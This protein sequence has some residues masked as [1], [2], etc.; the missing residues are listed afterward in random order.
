MLFT[1]MFFSSFFKQ[2]VEVL[3]CTIF[4][5]SFFVSLVLF[6]SVEPPK[7]PCSWKDR[8]NAHNQCGVESLSVMLCGWIHTN[9]ELP[10]A[11]VFSV[12]LLSPS[13]NFAQV[14]RKEL[15]CGFADLEQ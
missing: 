2:P 11:Q 15:G 5:K 3:C 9:L 4:D 8:G 14:K 10:Q 1:L 13:G 12:C 6:C 7:R